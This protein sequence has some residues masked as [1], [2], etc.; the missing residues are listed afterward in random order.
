MIDLVVSSDPKPSRY[1]MSRMKI[2]II[3]KCR[4]PGTY[5]AQS[6]LWKAR[7]FPHTKTC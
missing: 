5:L 3:P 7:R 2:A 1:A 4:Q 6:L